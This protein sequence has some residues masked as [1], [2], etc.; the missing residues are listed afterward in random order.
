[1]GF[2]RA[3]IGRQRVASLT[4]LSFG[5]IL[6]VV[7]C[8]GNSLPRD[9]IESGRKAVESFLTAWK[10][11]ESSEKLKD[12]SI[13]ASDPDW[14]AGLNL[15]DFQIT[16][17]EGTAPPN[18]R[19]WVKLNLKDRDGAKTDRDV[20]YEVNLRKEKGTTIISRDPFF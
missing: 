16:G 3:Q 11:G 1:M 2:H 15:I 18:P 19:F 17:T 5:L 14:I 10:Q 20:V 8:S 13:T 4:F 7:G 6:V 12:R 9:D